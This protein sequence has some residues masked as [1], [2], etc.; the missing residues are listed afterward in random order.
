MDRRRKQRQS[1]QRIKLFAAAG[2]AVLTLVLLIILLGGREYPAVDFSAGR[3]TDEYSGDTVLPDGVFIG[4]EYVGGLTK[5]EAMEKLRSIYSMPQNQTVRIY[6]EQQTVN[7]TLEQ[8]GASWGVE[9]A[10]NRAIT[11]ANGG[12]LA[13]RYKTSIDL[14]SGTYHI[15]LRKTLDRE[16]VDSFIRKEVSSVYDQK[17][18]N[19]SIEYEDGGFRVTDGKV[20]KVTDIDSSVGTVMDAFHE[21]ADG[22]TLTASVVIKNAFPEITSDALS[23]IKDRLGTYT[24]RYRKPENGRTDRCINV[25]VAT[26]YINGTVLMPGES[27]SASD[28]MK[29]R[30]VENGYA[31]GGQYVNGQVEDAVG[32]GVCQVSTT[33][34]N[35]LL[36]AEIQI[37]K[38]YA[39]SMN[40]SYVL[41]SEDAA[42]ALGSKDLVFTNNL[43]KPIYIYGDTDGYEVTFRIYGEEYRP[44]NRTL[45]FEA[46][47]EKRIESEDIIIEDP[48]LYV[49]E[50]KTDGSTHDEISSR[51]EKVVF[52]DGTEVS[53]EVLHSDYYMPSQAKVHVG[54]KPKPSEPAETPQTAASG[55]QENGPESSQTNA[56][57]D[58]E[59]GGEDGN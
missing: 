46:I 32:G 25:E 36:R 49:G 24:T 56:P 27:L 16:K 21:L 57:Q 59:T 10:I 19:A 34:Y 20:G 35:A 22:Q 51:L 18:V 5:D 9:H 39:H 37:D 7:T 58:G 4:T 54:T 14:S 55:S 44:A 8:L 52:I 30:N 50:K 29:E 26:A 53:R 6:W 2:A 17:P 13:Q 47:E 42:I 31:M 28:A 12:G 41:P 15:D 40:V 38:R 23:S 11:L 45:S 3:E 43:D 33:L 1:H 48:N